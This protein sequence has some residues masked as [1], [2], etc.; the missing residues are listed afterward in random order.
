MLSNPL[1][2]SNETRQV[3]ST[4]P[5][6][7]STFYQ[8]LLVMAYRGTAKE[9]LGKEDKMICSFQEPQTS[10]FAFLDTD[11]QLKQTSSELNRDMESSTNFKAGTGEGNG[12]TSF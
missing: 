9:E 10:S 6:P 3:A 5:C 8:D 11:K 1:A 4:D 7:Q 2:D 12:R